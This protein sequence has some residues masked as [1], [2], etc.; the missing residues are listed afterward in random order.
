MPEDGEIVVDIQRA[1][2]FEEQIKETAQPHPSTVLLPIAKI[3]FSGLK[4]APIPFLGWFEYAHLENN[5]QL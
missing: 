2:L 5:A 4:Y 3:Y 1:E